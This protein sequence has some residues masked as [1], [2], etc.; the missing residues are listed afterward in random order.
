MT[1]CE[2]TRV[3]L[4]LGRAEGRW[5]RLG[6]Y[7]AMFPVTFAENVII[8]YSSAGQTVIDPFC[9][10]GT[11]PFIAMVTGRRAVGCDINPVAWLYSQTKVDPHPNLGEVEERITQV[12]QSVEPGDD[13]P[14]HEFQ[15]LGFCRGVLGFI[16]SAQRILDWRR[17]RLD[18][19]VTALMVH[20]LHAY[21]DRDFPTSY[22]TLA[23]CLLG[24]PLT[25][26]VRK[27]TIF[28]LISTQGTS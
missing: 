27:V 10:R 14:E 24:I 2:Q 1:T 9:G 23:Q 4:D 7:Y 15:Q 16:R 21:S 12:C 11:A 3:S 8:Q 18:R 5:S 28:H 13:E 25:G 17:N 6:S 20:Y 22:A 26:G 19:T